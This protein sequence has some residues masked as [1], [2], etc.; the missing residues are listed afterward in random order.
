[1]QLEIWDKDIVDDDFMGL[2][3]WTLRSLTG[4]E[5]EDW[6]QLLPRKKKSPIRDL[7]KIRVKIQY[8]DVIRYTKGVVKDTGSKGCYSIFFDD[9]TVRKE[10]RSGLRKLHLQHNKIGDSGIRMLSSSLSKN[11]NLTNL[12][13]SDNSFGNFGCSALTK[14]LKENSTL[15]ILEIENNKIGDQGAMTIADCLKV[16]FSLT[17]LA[18]HGNNI[19]DKGA[20][21][22]ASALAVHTEHTFELKEDSTNPWGIVMNLEDHY[23]KWRVI[24]M[25]NGKQAEQL[26]VRFGD[27]FLCVDGVEI[28]DVNS[29]VISKTLFEGAACQITIRRLFHANFKELYILSDSLIEEQGRIS[30]ETSQKKNANWIAL[31]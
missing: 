24:E 2:V 16:N 9:G 13:V 7:G 5:T 1:M 21:A 6:F 8:Q 12:N 22:I 23:T 31:A 4:D 11:S 19:S 28:N 10:C 14:K 26:G 27:I 17:K 3:S 18:V 30:L 20:I 25:T 29:K 15:Q